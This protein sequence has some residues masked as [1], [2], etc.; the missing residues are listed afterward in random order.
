VLPGTRL[1]LYSDGVSERRRKDGRLFGLAGIQ[2]ALQASRG[3]SVDAT[4][5]CLQDAV[6]RASDRPLRDDATL[7]I[8]A[9]AGD[10]EARFEE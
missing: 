9:P 10:S 5:R 4:V 6:L 8:L 7:L 1:V 3:A 2:K